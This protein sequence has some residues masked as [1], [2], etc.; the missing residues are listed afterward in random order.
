MTSAPPTAGGR[1]HS[2][3]RLEAG[4]YAGIPSRKATYEPMAEWSSLVGDRV[5]AGEVIGTINGKK[6]N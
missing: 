4:S 6:N 3:T 2:A 1:A 5:A